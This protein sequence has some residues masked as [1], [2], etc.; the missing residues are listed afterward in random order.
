MLGVS[1][2]NYCSLINLDNI[3][4]KKSYK[5]SRIIPP[6]EID[7]FHISIGATKSCQLDIKFKF[8]VDSKKI[9][10][11]KDFI[12]KIRSYLFSVIV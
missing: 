3:P 4:D 11:S 5:I 7:K 2:T 12:L 8:I 1:D 10:E 6:N 9:V